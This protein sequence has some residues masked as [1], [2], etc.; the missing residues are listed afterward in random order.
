MEEG[1]ERHNDSLSDCLQKLPAARVINA[2]RDL[3]GKPASER[4]AG[5]PVHVLPRA[6][7]IS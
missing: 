6:L 5:A 3:S 2:I 7:P 1:C 4:V